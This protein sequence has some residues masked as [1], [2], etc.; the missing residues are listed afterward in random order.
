MHRLSPCLALSFALSSALAAGQTT[1]P[2]AGNSIGIDVRPCESARFS[3]EVPL[4]AKALESTFEATFAN[5][6]SI[7]PDWFPSTPTSPQRRVALTQVLKDRGAAGGV[8]EREDGHRRA[9]LLTFQSRPNDWT[10]WSDETPLPSASCQII[11]A[12][13]KAASVAQAVQLPSGPTAPAFQPRVLVSRSCDVTAQDAEAW[14]TFDATTWANERIGA[15]STVNGTPV[16]VALVDTGVPPLYREALGVVSERSLPDF[17]PKA[18]DYHPHGTQMAALIH[19]AAPEARIRSYRALDE[20]GMGSLSA[21]ARA[22]DDALYDGQLKHPL[23]VNVSV[24][25]PP[26]FLRP[27]RLQSGTC[28]TWEDGTGEALRYVF[29]VA[30]RLGATGTPV[31]ISAAGGNSALER[32]TSSTVLPWTLPIPATPCGPAPGHSTFFPATLGQ[33][34]SCSEGG[35]VHLAVQPMGASTWDDRIS[36]LTRGANGL[37]LYAPGERV[38]ATG[39][40][41]PTSGAV[42]CGPGDLG[43]Q[44]GFELPAAVTGTSASAALTS[45]AAFLLLGHP[46]SSSP[47]S[48]ADHLSRLLY[49][50]GQPLCAPVN[51]HARRISIKRAVHA[52]S[53]PSP[54]CAALRACLQ[55]PGHAAGQVGE[56]T[57]ALCWAPM[58]ACFGGEAAPACPNFSQEPGWQPGHY[59]AI[60]VAAPSCRASWDVAGAQSPSPAA[61]IAMYPDVHLAGL[62]PQP[63]GTGCPDCSLQVDELSMTLLFE[64]NDSYPLATRFTNPWVVLLDENRLPVAW[65]PVGDGRLAW[66]PGEVGRLAIEGLDPKQL[67]RYARLL[68]A[69]RLTPVLDLAVVPVRGSPGR[70]ASP[71]RVEPR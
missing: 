37:M 51:K 4:W 36:V 52:I 3:I 12:V 22:V 61:P 8:I 69:G 6:L 13:R 20:R 44:R 67:T 39:A 14:A 49:L 19:A 68:S 40:T 9:L 11:T 26:D 48:S 15:G 29:H 1:P 43:G 64:L 32:S 59:A 66:R 17:E 7:E 55:H 27:A 50:T 41:T 28:T 57:A 65:L 46:W 34:P 35:P 10:N 60:N 33:S 58:Q 63:A 25:M 2:Y 42:A 53:A 21:L 24:G 31:F 71:L 18:A 56:A 47:P 30:T 45:A 38:Y 70:L 16:T 23:V 54:G 5:T 62:G